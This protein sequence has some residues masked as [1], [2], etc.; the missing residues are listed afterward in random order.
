LA[1]T[2]VDMNR[3]LGS[4]RPVLT[5][6]ALALCVAGFLGAEA[7]SQG[8]SQKK[9]IL[10]E[11]L[12]SIDLEKQL[13]KR[14]GQ[15]L[16]ELE[17]AAELLKDSIAAIKKQIVSGEENLGAPAGG[18]EAAGAANG[19]ASQAAVDFKRFLPKNVFDWIV[20]IVGGVAI[21]SGFVLVAGL[22][23]L[24]FRKK[25]KAPRPLHDM[26]PQVAA[27]DIPQRIP[28]VPGGLTE[29]KDK[30][31]EDIRKRMEESEKSGPENDS[32]SGTSDEPAARP[33]LPAGTGE[34]KTAKGHAGGDETRDPLEI[35]KQV[36][37][38]SQQGLDVQEISR[39]Y[40]LSADQVSLILRIAR[41]GE[42]NT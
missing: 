37:R 9:R 13:R 22:F 29:L 39:R 24:L 16:E 20:V 26:F 32:V 8:V 33:V 21:I 23:G 10:T 19:Q 25:K 18:R 28:K 11:K 41:Q 1:R 34:T 30:R 35:K 17:R 12:D 40:H 14:K 4:V 6:A 27:R 5:T 38:A 31:L 3:L 7:F 42:N 36:I 15:S 2:L